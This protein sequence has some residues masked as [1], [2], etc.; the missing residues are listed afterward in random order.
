M[1]IHEFVKPYEFLLGTWEG[2]GRGHYSTIESFEYLETV[3]FSAIPGKPFVRYEQKTTS[4]DGAPM[5][6]ETGYFRPQ[7]GGHVE[8]VIAQPMG[9]TE[10][11][12]GNS[13]ANDDGSL[14]LVLGYAEI[15]NTTTA[16]F[17]E[18]TT[19]H[20]V[21]NADRTAFHHEFD[22]SAVG[23]ELQNHLVAE[24]TKVS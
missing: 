15:R 13:T 22:M 18:N 1:S 24:L 14:T 23:E 16:K 17:V 8:F 10:L 12:E 21:F 5:H 20:Y 2:S 19:R 7:A 11:L 4:H 9:Q 3:T 6:T